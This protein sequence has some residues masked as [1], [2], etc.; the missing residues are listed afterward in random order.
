MASQPLSDARCRGAVW[1]CR[2]GQ[3]AWHLSLAARASL[4]GDGFREIRSECLCLDGKLLRLWIM[5]ERST[6]GRLL[7][8]P[9]NV[10]LYPLTD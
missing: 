10:L 4:S 7:G 3:V 9:S 5:K 6:W 2:Q 8:S 1:R